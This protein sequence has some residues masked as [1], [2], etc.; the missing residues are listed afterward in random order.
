MK[1][2]YAIVHPTATV[3]PT[4][5]LG[6]PYRQLQE[7]SWGG[8]PEAPGRIGPRVWIGD[9]AVI[10]RGVKVGADTIIDTYCQVQGGSR[11]GRG[12]I[13]C[14]GAAV[15]TNAIVGDDAVIGVGG[16]VCSGARVGARARVFGRLIHRQ[17][18]PDLPWDAPEAQEPSPRVAAGAFVGCGAV[19]IGDILVGA[20]AYLCAGAVV[21]RSVPA[22]YI[23]RGVNELVHPRD[24][25]GPL[26]GF[27]PDRAG[28]KIK[29]V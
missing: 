26:E 6:A 2:P 21:T 11:I 25:T 13:V 18:R 27:F 29:G 8:D 19:V 9:F 3:A 23:V 20:G 4:A 5:V 14:D 15:S 17:L 16:Y 1:L 24:W 12:V 22:G 10:G 7:G 28:G